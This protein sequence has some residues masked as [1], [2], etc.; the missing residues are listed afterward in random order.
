MFLG[1]SHRLPVESLIQLVQELWGISLVSV[2]IRL[3][4]RKLQL[5]SRWIEVFSERFVRADLHDE[6]NLKDLC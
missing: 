5:P 2:E 3:P 1:S 4:S 6:S